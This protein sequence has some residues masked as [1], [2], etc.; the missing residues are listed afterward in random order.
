MA[1]SP[2]CLAC[3]GQVSRPSRLYPHRRSPRDLN[4]TTAS[5]LTQGGA[6]DRLAS[7]VLMPAFA[8]GVR[9]LRRPLGEVAV[10]NRPVYVRP[11]G[12]GPTSD[13]L[14]AGPS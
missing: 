7:L 12:E 8:R 13:S 6:C 2:V 5:S 1:G 4:A 3:R 10:R 14:L 9:W 11:L